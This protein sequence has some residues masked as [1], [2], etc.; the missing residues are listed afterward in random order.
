MA[1]GPALKRVFDID[2]EHCPSV[3]VPPTII[4][5]IE[6]SR[7]RQDPHAFGL[8]RPGTAPSTARVFDRFQ[9]A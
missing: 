9:L 2:L 7:D 8:I 5:A 6:D 3:V 4:A 1:L